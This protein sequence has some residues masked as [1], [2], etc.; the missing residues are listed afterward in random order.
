ME[1][2]HYLLISDQDSIAR[3]L[4]PQVLGKDDKLT[5]AASPF[6][7]LPIVNGYKL[8][9]VMLA[10]EEGDSDAV[11]ACRT[12]RRH[13]KVPIVMLV[14]DHARDQIPRGYRLGA[15]AHIQIPCD[16]REFRARVFA[17]LRR[18]AG[19]A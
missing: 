14:N 7:A 3:S 4:L 2:H 5:C 12:L 13:S 15:D 11:L 9:A 16:P 19:R 17:V 18:Y 1:L 6:E 10:V 8:D